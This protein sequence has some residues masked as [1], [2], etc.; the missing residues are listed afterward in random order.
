MG[1]K[2]EGNHEP[3]HYNPDIEMPILLSIYSMEEKAALTRLSVEELTLIRDELYEAGRAMAI[4]PNWSTASELLRR[5][6]AVDDFILNIKESK[7]NPMELFNSKEYPLDLDKEPTM[8]AYGVDT[9]MRDECEGSAP[10]GAP[11]LVQSIA[12]FFDTGFSLCYFNNELREYAQAMLDNGFTYGIRPISGMR[13]Y[14][15]PEPRLCWYKFENPFYIYTQW[16]HTLPFSFQIDKQMHGLDMNIRSSY[17][18][19]TRVEYRSLAKYYL[20]KAV[21]TK[22]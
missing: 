22:K 21:E 11:V 13:E 6:S 5:S 15:N 7:L 19:K 10:S 12:V 3:S 8:R 17:R 16:T 1:L 9:R 18:A 14:L 2:K 20:N 4:I